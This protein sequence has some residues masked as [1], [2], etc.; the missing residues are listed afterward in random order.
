MESTPNCIETESLISPKDLNGTNLTPFEHAKKKS[1][2]WLM[3]LYQLRGKAGETPER[4]LLGVAVSINILE[5]MMQDVLLG[6]EDNAWAGFELMMEPGNL[7]RILRGTGSAIDMEVYKG[8]PCLNNP[9][10]VVWNNLYTSWN[11]GHNSIE[12]KECANKLTNQE[13]PKGF[14]KP[15]KSSFCQFKMGPSIHPKVA[16]H[17]K[18]IVELTPRPSAQLTTTGHCFLPNS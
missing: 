4:Y 3:K 18:I 5:A 1:V 10:P 12:L 13:V 16:L 9:L 15:T 11:L 6:N 2:K 14:L 17:E 7:D 8:V